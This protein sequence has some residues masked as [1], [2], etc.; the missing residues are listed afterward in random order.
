MSTNGQLV[1]TDVD[2][3]TFKGVGNTSNAVVDTVTG[4]IGV[5]IDSPDANLHVLGNS[6]VSTNLEL[7]GTLIMG[8]VN[9][10]AHHSL[11]AVTAEGNTTPLT[12]E[13]SNATTG[14]V[15]TGNVEVGNEL[16]V[17]GNLNVTTVMS[18][19]NV[20]TEYTGP[21]DR[22][23][24]K[25]PEVVLTA[26]DNLSTS[27]Y[28][29]SVSS[30]HLSDAFRAFDAT[31]A[32][33]YWHSQY[34]YYTHVTGTYNPGQ[35][36][37]G[38][39]TPAN[40]TTLPTTE[41]ISGHQGE[42]IKLQMPTRIKLEEVRVYA[43]NRAASSIYQMPKDIAIAGSND[44]TNWYLVDS[45]TLRTGIRESYG[46]ASLPV[47]TSSYYSHLALIVKSIDNQGENYSAAEI[48]NIEYYGREEG[49]ASLDTTLKTVYNVPATTGTQ[50]EV[51]YDGQN[52]TSGSTVNDLALPANN[53]TLNGGVG[54]D[55]TYKAFTFNASSNQYIS[56]STPISGNYVHSMSMWFKP[57]GLT[58]TS[59]DTILFVGDNTNNNKI[60]VFIESD[61]INYTFKGND[62]QAYPQFLNNVW[63]HLTLTY[64]GQVGESGREI[65]LNG[66]KLQ[67]THS[68]NSVVLNISNNALD[69]G[70]FT[71]SG[72]STA[73]AFDGSIANFRLYSKALNADQV[74]ELYDYQK[75]YFLGSKSQL[76]LYKGYLG[77]GVTE[78]SGQLEL[79]GDERLQEYPP[80]DLYQYDT[81]IEGHGV[82]CV[83]ASIEFNNG[84]H[85]AWEAFSDSATTGGT[86]P[87][88]ESVWTT[89]GS[90]YH[91]SSG[92]Y[93]GSTTTA[94]IK[95][96]W[97]QL[98][99]PY[100]IKISSFN[101]NSYAD[102]N[103]DRQPR[104]FILLGSNDGNV[105]EQ[106]KSVAGQT[107]G[108]TM[109]SPYNTSP[110]GPHHTVNSTKYYNY[111][112]IVVTANQGGDALVGISRIR[113]YGTP[114][115]TTLD[116]GSLSLT[117]SLDVP[118]I[119]RYDVDTETPRPEKLIFD[120]DTSVNS[121][122]TDISGK[123]N[124]GTFYGDAYY[125]EVD[126]A[127][128]FDGTN[129][130][131]YVDRNGSSLNGFPTGD[132][133]YTMSCWVKPQV[134]GTSS[135]LFYF[136]SSWTTSQLAGI[137]FSSANGI[138]MDVGSYYIA[139]A[140]NTI[141]ADEWV[142]VAIVKRGTGNVDNTHSWGSIYINGV[143]VSTTIGAGGGQQA[144]Q[145]I[146]NLSIGSNFNG[147]P[148]SFGEDF[149]GC[150]A[151]P[152][153]W[154][155]P[156]ENSEIR[157]LYN[158]GRTGRSMV[159]SDTA[160]GIGKAPEAQL[161]VRGVIRGSGLS[162]QTVSSTKTDTS[163]FSGTSIT[164]I[165]G[166]SITI[167]PKFANSKIYV[168]YHI[169]YGGQGRIFFR[170]KRTQGSS[171][172]YFRS[173]L[174]PLDHASTSRST[175]T[176]AFDNNDGSTRSASF[177]TLDDANSLEPITYTVEGW[178]Y[179]SVY[180]VCVNRAYN[181]GANPN[182]SYYGRGISSISAQEVCQ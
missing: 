154:S 70:R 101:L 130:T 167:Q 110:T 40:G 155:V 36:A 63:H 122:P 100:K 84:D 114:G 141:K 105:W 109:P 32:T 88:D 19:S 85:P 94:G 6:Y 117:R 35:S 86:G 132:A 143:E 4:K 90:V 16:T 15:T 104:D 67:G 179:H 14:I 92:L 95:G 71:P 51:Y 112:R 145:T 1:F 5:G 26:D 97:I 25:Y 162:I 21:H 125:S 56:T 115:P 148:G 13:F 81:N 149:D 102:A 60:E 3:I 133:T 77:I 24:R 98:K 78:P 9:V 31:G 23:L 55:S 168:G 37:G 160:V 113:F 61:R 83:S 73:Y 34:P 12:V 120:Y 111:F 174:G 181:E 175:T 10:S 72:T 180:Y 163:F 106:M 164:D 161:D 144:L 157:K 152:Q 116:K 47:T 153:I 39:G 99:T 53:G 131:V 182:Q 89:D 96:E 41:L 28:K 57:T 136:G 156:L 11:E 121:S 46:M 137:Y 166:L 158:L 8:T 44:G 45:G 103:S 30:Q 135:A 65:Y 142:H 124:H 127:F 118:H 58:A 119:S 173:D 7:G 54:F 79:A 138:N 93:T 171:T 108:Y 20:V 176:D 42:W 146:D 169:L 38:T 66:K 43:S 48:A 22:P 82:F 74:K 29:A 68:G 172:S 170:L 151:K 87:H 128:K 126:K 159:I 129:D 140:S 107:S 139:T 91:L 76:T 165:G 17:T 123:G 62:Y 75:D 64:N 49:D 177:F 178:T 18:D 27:G 80:R 50:L 69:I 147:S 52:Y 2:K 150:I 59:G 33:T 134:L